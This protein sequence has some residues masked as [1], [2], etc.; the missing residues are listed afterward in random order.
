MGV[1]PYDCCVCGGGNFRCGNKNCKNKDY[2]GNK[3]C[4][5]D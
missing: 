1:F 5:E 4:W 3:F 2:G